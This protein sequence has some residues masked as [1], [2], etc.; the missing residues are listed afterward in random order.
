LLFAP[1]AWTSPPMLTRAIP[2]I[3]CPDAVSSMAPSPTRMVPCVFNK[4]AAV[5]GCNLVAI[6]PPESRLNCKLSEAISR[7]SVLALSTLIKPCVMFGLAAMMLPAVTWPFSAIELEPLP[8]SARKRVVLGSLRSGVRVETS[9]ELT[10]TV[11]PVPKIKPLGL[12]IQ[13][14]PFVAP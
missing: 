3:R 2:A 12:M 10:L 7:T 6:K 13:T 9:K 1:V 5:E 11:E 14:A 8:G 4:V